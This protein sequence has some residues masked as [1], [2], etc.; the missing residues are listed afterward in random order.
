M[1]DKTFHILLVDDD[2]DDYMII[3]DTLSG[4]RNAAYL[5][6]WAAAYEDALNMIGKSQYDACLMDYRLGW[7]NGI[8]LMKDFFA[9]GFQAPIIILTGYGDY[10]IDLQAMK[11]GAFDYLE[12]A[13]LTAERLERSIRYAVEKWLMLTE[14][15]KSEKKVRVLSSKVI[16]LQE[17][18][19]KLIAREL[20]DSIGA[21]LTA[22]KFAME[23]KL[24]KMKKSGQDRG[25]RSL[26]HIIRMVGDTIEETRRLSYHL[27]PSILD[28]F[29]LIPAVH[30]MTKDF[31]EVYKDIALES[32]I[33]AS[34]ESVPEYLKI[35]IYRILQESLN[36]VS[37]HSGADRVWIFLGRTAEGLEMTLK[38]NG[39][40]FS[41]E[42]KA[43]DH[44]HGHGMGLE[45]MRERAEIS[46]G[47]FQCLSEPGKGTTIR[48]L[49]SVA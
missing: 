17:K 41:P 21:N 42:Q 45:G 20:H 48:A 11:E 28:D 36:N 2:E 31:Q 14:L 12:K 3:R 32:D 23:T 29:G 39:R 26:E 13:K 6:D 10:D 30:S 44:D 38:D 47:R 22:I 25:D 16:G 27:R 19:R 4:I 33:R 15:K 43:F 18:E 49:W 5:L 46:D 9:A 40:G 34:E 7:M 8:S 1:S 24:G 35:V 37:K